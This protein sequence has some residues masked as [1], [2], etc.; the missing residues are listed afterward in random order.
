MYACVVMPNHAHV[1]LLP[2]EGH[3]LAQIMKRIKGVSARKINL[4]LGREGTV[5]QAD[6]FDRYIRDEYDFLQKLSYVEENPVAAG[7]VE[8]AAAWQCSSAR[9]ADTPV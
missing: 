2:Y 4:L 1:V 8:D 3:S 7:L 9:R 6:Y 5:W